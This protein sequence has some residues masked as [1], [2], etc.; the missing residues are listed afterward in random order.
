MKKLLTEYGLAEEAI[1]TRCK[2]THLIAR[3]MNNWKSLAPSFGLSEPD[4]TAIGIDGRDEHDRRKRLLDEWIRRNG[5]E[6]TNLLLVEICV[7]A[8][9][10]ALADAICHY[11]ATGMYA[12]HRKKFITLEYP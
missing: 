2:N 10:S 1:N 4:I 7:K 11:L 8:G 9:E 12:Y 3:L 6:A 5:F